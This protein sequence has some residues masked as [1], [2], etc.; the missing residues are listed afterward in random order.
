MTHNAKVVTKIE[1]VKMLEDGEDLI[2][3]GYANTISKDRVGDVIPK[4]TWEKASALT[5]YLKN[6]IILAQHNHS[7][8]IGKM[9]SHEITDFGLKIAAKISKGAG[10]T[11]QLIKDGVLSTFSVGIGILDAEYDSKSETYFINEVEL[12]EV[13]VVSIPCN[14][15]SVFSVAKSMEQSEFNKFKQ[16]LTKPEGNQK[17]ET[18]MTFDA[19]KFAQELQASTAKTVQDTINAE[20]AKE[21]AAAD[22]AAAAV[23]AKAQA[24]ADAMEAAKALTQELEDK[25]K[26]SAEAFAEAH[27]ANEATIAANKEEMLALQNEVKALANSRNNPVSGAVAKA[28]SNDVTA[29]EVDEVVMLGMIKKL[30]MFETKYGKQHLATKAVNASSSIQVSSDAYETTFRTNLIR[31]IEQQLRIAPLFQEITM[32]SANLTVPVDEGRKNANWV[33]AADYG[34]DASTGNEITV[35]LTER[36]LKTFK[37]A[38]KTYL[39]EETDE[40]AIIAVLPILR[41]HLVDAHANEIDRAFLLGTGTGQPK[42]LITQA[43]AIG[44]NATHTGAATHTGTTLVTAAEILAARAKLGL[45]GINQSDLA[46]V[47]SQD[48]YY[49]LIQDP[50]WADVNQVNGAAT[51]LTGEV[52]AIYGMPVIVSGQFAA[53]AAST[54]YGMIVNKKNFVVP[55]QRGVTLRSEFETTKDRRV[56]VATQRLNLEPWFETVAG[57]GNGKGVVQITYAA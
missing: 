25:L 27:K 30:P 13:S 21:K 32:N 52:G 42:G 19:E 29:K 50:A 2:I 37:I 51:K 44:V 46:L 54:A 33:D 36:T 7:M 9:I 22:K 17:E 45:Y 5:N 57:N 14:Q 34:T 26:I 31:D 56:F 1:S 6:P 41:R 55:R 20:K 49:D 39:T 35:A 40:D 4:E 38:A 53:K 15:D 28:L 11:Y 12:T 23:A 16:E 18:N 10:N 3:E 47:V 48:A 8:P 24:K 43:A